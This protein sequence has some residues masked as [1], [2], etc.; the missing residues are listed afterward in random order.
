MLR[1]A[2]ETSPS[3]KRHRDRP[4]ARHDAEQDRKARAGRREAE[5]Y[6]ER[7]KTVQPALAHN[8]VP[9]KLEGDK[10]KRM[11]SKTKEP[12]RVDSVRRRDDAGKSNEQKNSRAKDNDE[13]RRQASKDAE[14]RRQSS[15]NA[16]GTTGAQ[17]RSEDR[18]KPRHKASKCN[19]KQDC[20]VEKVDKPSRRDVGRTPTD[21]PQA[22]VELGRAK[23][24]HSESH[25]VISAQQLARR[26]SGAPN[27]G[28]SSTIHEEPSLLESQNT[29]R[30]LRIRQMSMIT[31][32][33]GSF[34]GFESM[35]ST[36]LTMCEVPKEAPATAAE[37]PRALFH[38]TGPLINVNVNLNLWG[39]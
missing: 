17:R 8:E 16:D 24:S 28:R 32:M 13:P 25:D 6:G 27:E 35:E 34:S 36:E 10:L 37:P 38:I 23:S 3:G 4:E 21:M 20:L 19:K 12:R 7:K 31:E 18:E 2:H 9:L 30:S 39:K 29:I 26:S 14:I 22:T 33:P 5:K 15:K 11:P 1:Q